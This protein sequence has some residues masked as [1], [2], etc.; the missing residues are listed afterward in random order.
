MEK[1]V[2]ISIHG[3]QTDRDGVNEEIELVTCGSLQGD[4]EQ[5][6]HLTYDESELTGLDGTTTT[7]HIGEKQITLERTGSLHSEMVFREGQRHVS[8]YET[9][10]GGL[11]IGINTEKAWADIDQDGGRLELRYVIDVENTVIGKNAFRIQV[12]EPAVPTLSV[13]K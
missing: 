4:G 8:L 3:T 9:G 7:F 12:R 1:S 10:L 2:I 11:M 13:E 5:G 6:Y